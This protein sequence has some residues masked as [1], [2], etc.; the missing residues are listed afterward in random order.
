[1]K[2]VL[3]YILSVIWGLPMT[4]VGGLTALVLM[5]AGF[6]PKRYGWCYYFEIGKNWGGLELGII[7]LVNKNSSRYTRNHEHGHALQNCIW[8]PL[9]PFVIS[10]PSAIRYWVRE[11]QQRQGKV[12][13]PYDSIWFEGQ[14]T[15]WG[16]TFME[17][18][19]NQE[20]AVK[21]YENY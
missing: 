17:Q 8:G 1:M 9:M 18:Y 13:K 6:K 5:I 15:R 10:I 4:L 21:T 16:Q 14:A 19:N 3:F 7:F 20:R 12:L 11:F 2:K